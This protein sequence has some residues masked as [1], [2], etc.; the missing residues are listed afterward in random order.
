MPNNTGFRVPA[1]EAS[2]Q[3]TALVKVKKEKSVVIGMTTDQVVM[4]ENWL[5]AKHP[6]VNRSKVLRTVL[7]DLI[8][9]DLQGPS[10]SASPEPIAAPETVVA[11]S[12][13][14]V[15]ATLASVPVADPLRL[16]MSSELMAQVQRMNA[17]D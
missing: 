5:D 8:Q 2:V 11:T 6:G 3:V 9:K 15:Q 7:L 1:P 13:P 14:E 12:V 17:L 16:A 4:V 10:A